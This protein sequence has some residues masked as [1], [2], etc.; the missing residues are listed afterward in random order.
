MNDREYAI[1]NYDKYNLYDR[2]GKPITQ[3]DMIKLLEILEAYNESL[4]NLHELYIDGN[5]EFC[6]VDFWWNIESD[7]QIYY[8]IR[9][10]HHVLTEEEFIDYMLWELQNN[11]NNADYI[12]KMLDRDIH[13]TSNGY[14]IFCD[15]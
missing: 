10:H 7:S 4:D 2:E 15:F 9:E 11:D 5:G 1:A 3:S 13:K 6:G 14:V 12:I 8:V